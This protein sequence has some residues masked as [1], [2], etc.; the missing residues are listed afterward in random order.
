M[1]DDPTPDPVDPEPVVDPT[2]E[3]E[4]KADPTPEPAADPP[5][6][7][8]PKTGP[9]AAE[10]AELQAKL[11]A[12]NKE[13]ADRRKKLDELERAQESESEKRVR[14]AVDAAHAANKPRIVR[15]E[16]KL[17]LMGADARPERVAALTKFLDLDA[18]EV[19][20][21]DVTGLDVQVD[22][23]KVDYPEFFK[24]PDDVKPPVKTAPKATTAPKKPADTE[25]KTAGDL[26]AAQF[27]FK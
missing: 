13:S 19:D 14:E 26:I 16:A 23:L 8:A 21:E 27:G 22:Q 15:A 20:G 3:P 7:T 9:T 12:A 11:R 6:P 18:I 25:H 5:K 24:V 2:P 10:Y 4:P 1:A 17:A